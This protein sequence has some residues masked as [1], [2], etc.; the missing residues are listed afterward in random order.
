MAL[1]LAIPAD[2]DESTV[3]AALREGSALRAKAK[4][5]DKPKPAD[6]FDAHCRMFGLPPWA[7][8][9]MFA[10]K[11]G[12]QW[13][14]DFCWHEYKIAVEIEGLVVRKL[15]GQL[16][17]M[18]RHAS[19]GGFKEDCIKYASAALL[20]WTVVRF[21]QSQVTDKTAIDYTMRILQARGWRPE[22]GDAPL[23]SAIVPDPSSP[24]LNFDNLPF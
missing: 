4:K 14:F 16:V 17:V 3:R 20:G 21:E 12:R 2:A 5:R 9:G 7:R 24:E 15:A 18:G 19:I 13:L 11:I 8:E 23:P 10:K 1:R 6:I 22:T